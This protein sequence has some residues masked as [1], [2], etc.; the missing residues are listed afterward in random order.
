MHSS[1][2]KCGGGK[3]GGGL[4][5]YEPAYTQT[6]YTIPTTPKMNPA[7]PK[8]LGEET[9]G[10]AVNG[11]AF[12]SHAM[13]PVFD[14]CLGHTS[15]DHQ[16]HYHLAPKCLL[17]TLYGADFKFPANAAKFWSKTC[18]GA[19]CKFADKGKASP[20]VGFAL[21]GYPIYALYDSEGVLQTASMLDKCQGKKDKQGNYGYYITAQAPYFPQCLMG[22]P[23]KVTTKVTSKACKS[24]S[25]KPKTCVKDGTAWVYAGTKNA[26][27]LTKPEAKPSGVSNVEV[28]GWSSALALSAAAAALQM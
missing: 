2:G 13:T 21:D 22:V 26:C 18:T 20:V 27:T 17:E 5:K 9:F 4:S 6:E 14:N 19:G 25:S 23:G 15:D 11:V 10:V 16:Y 24:P 7:G 3:G 8:K 12:E 28:A 1:I